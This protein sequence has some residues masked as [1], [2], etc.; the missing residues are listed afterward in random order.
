MRYGTRIWQEQDGKTAY[1]VQTDNE[2]VHHYLSQQK[3]FALVG[4]GINVSLWIYRIE[5]YSFQKAHSI[6]NSIST[7]KI[8]VY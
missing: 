5:S 6:L 2:S 3:D 4:W 1:R 7:G 8:A